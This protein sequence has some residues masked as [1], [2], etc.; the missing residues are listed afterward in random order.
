[1]CFNVSTVEDDLKHRL[2]R[3]ARRLMDDLQNNSRL[4][5]MNYKGR[6]S[7]QIQCTYPRTSKSIIDE[8]DAVVSQHLDFTTEESD[9]I[10][11]YDIKYRMGDADGAR[12]Q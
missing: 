9:F 10:V 6:G 5:R 12:E 11:N 4:V 3:L 8:I 7:L 2:S 1:M